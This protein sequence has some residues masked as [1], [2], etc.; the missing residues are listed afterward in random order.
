MTEQVVS[1]SVEN[2][3]MILNWYTLAF[4]KNKK[5]IKQ[6]SDLYNKLVVM[7]NALVDDENKI[8]KL[9]KDGS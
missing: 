5:M 3:K 9:M 1:L 7:G 2:Y 4:G 6:D 8:K